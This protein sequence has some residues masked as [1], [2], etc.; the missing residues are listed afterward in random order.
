MQHFTFQ[1]IGTI[2]TPHSSLE[3]MPIQPIG[4]EAAKGYILLKE[5]FVEGLKDLEGFTHL[6]LIYHLH[7]VTNYQMSVVPYMDDKAH[8]VFATRSPKRPNAIGL[9]TVKLVKV[10]DNKIFIEE[11]DMLDKTPLLDIKPFFRQFD[12][13]MDARSGWLDEKDADLVLKTKSDNRFV[14]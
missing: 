7:K 11:V 6:T 2:Y 3:N 13:R 12:N 8:G 10:E 4:A 9:S 1:P 5:E 14:E